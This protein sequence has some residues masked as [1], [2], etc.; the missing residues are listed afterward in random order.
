MAPATS[1]AR[2]MLR[3]I[4]LK[5][6][7]DYRRSILLWGIALVLYAG[8]EAQA[9]GKLFHGPDRDAKLADVGRLEQ[10]FALVYGK[11]YDVSSFG[12]YATSRPVLFMTIMLAIMSLLAGAGLLRREETKGTLD[13][14]LSTPRSRLNVLCQKWAGLTVVVAL[15][16]AIAATGLLASAKS[17]DLTLSAGAV[18]AEFITVWLLTVF[19]GTLALAISQ[20]TSRRAAAGWTGATVVA[21]CLLNNLADGVHSLRFLRY[22]SPFHYFGLNRPLAHEV[23][24][25]TTAIIVLVGLIGSTLAAAVGMYSSRDQGD[26]FRFGS[27]DAVRPRARRVPW[28]RDVR[29]RPG[30]SVRGQPVRGQPVRRPARAGRHRAEPAHRRGRR[31]AQPE[32]PAHR[33]PRHARRRDPARRPG[34]PPWPNNAALSLDNTYLFALRAEMVP[35]AVWGATIG[36]YA[37]LMLSVLHDIKDSMANL[38]GIYRQLGIDVTPSDASVLDATVFILATVLMG[39]YAV[40]RAGAWATEETAGRLELILSTPTPRWR[41]LLARYAAALTGAALAVMVFA[42]LFLTVATVKDTDLDGDHLVAAFVGLWVLI[43]IFVS[44]GFAV[45]AL[46]PNA[47][48]PVVATVVAVSF[49]LQILAGPLD[50]PKWL[51]ELSAFH[52]YG[53]P[54]VGGLVATPQLVELAVGLSTTLFAAVL[55]SRRDISKP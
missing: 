47:T 13:I 50:L 32:R 29:R 27:A 46:Y 51:V 15:I 49:L 3:S 39:V 6:I 11:V 36:A 53:Q 43:V 7:R 20:L 31:A 40:A 48:T 52:Q 33:R 28:R 37:A 8:S 18:Y 23:G 38:L 22:V 24:F 10:S 42:G 44:V 34:R 55:F 5:T 45:S 35:A 12:G 30:Q 14:L 41:I 25:D 54:L 4:F 26:V 2:E 16:V 1:V 9:Y 17:Q 21:T 19:F